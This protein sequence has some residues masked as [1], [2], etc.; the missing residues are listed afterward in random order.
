MSLT[1]LSEKNLPVDDC[2]RS[3]AAIRVGF[4]RYDIHGRQDID[5]EGAAN[6]ATERSQ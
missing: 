3:Q 2:Y 6:G 4:L 1:C 5:T